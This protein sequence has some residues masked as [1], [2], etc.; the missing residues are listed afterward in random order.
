MV[1]QDWT[2]FTLQ[3]PRYFPGQY[4]LNEDFALT[5]QY[6]SDRHRYLNSKLH[7]AGVLEGL[8]VEAIA[9]QLEVLVKAGSAIDGEGNLVVLSE[10]TRRTIHSAGWLCLRYHQEAKLLQQPEIP[11]SFTR[12]VETPMLI[13]SHAKLIIYFSP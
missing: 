4:L 13:S 1:Q 11:D 9:G 2:N 10:T 12:F 6:L 3:R 7:L 8:E 5:H